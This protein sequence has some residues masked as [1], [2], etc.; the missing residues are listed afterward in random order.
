M[1][2]LSRIAIG[3]VLA[4]ATLGS[5]HAQDGV[6]TFL[7]YADGI[8]EIEIGYLNGERESHV[9]DIGLR[10]S[11]RQVKDAENGKVAMV[12]DWSLELNTTQGESSRSAA[13]RVHA[14][15]ADR[16]RVVAVVRVAV[17]QVRLLVLVAGEPPCL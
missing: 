16:R 13:A 9:F 14:R 11:S 5:V 2:A 15:Q 7:R 10:G 17:L 1:F 6:Y 4:F 3:A 8:G 12:W